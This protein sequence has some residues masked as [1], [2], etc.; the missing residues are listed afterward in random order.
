MHARAVLKRPTRP[1]TPLWM[2]PMPSSPQTIDRN[3]N[4]LAAT[5][6]LNPHNTEFPPYNPC[7]LA[8]PVLVAAKMR[9]MK[10]EEFITRRRKDL[11]SKGNE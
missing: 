4:L 10:D 1:T 5:M 11:K 8:L 3:N 2:M 9:E 7:L 6:D